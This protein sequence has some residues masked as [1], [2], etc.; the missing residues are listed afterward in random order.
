MDVVHISHVLEHVRSP[1]RTLS[2]VRRLLRSG[3]HLI[4]ETPNAAT[5]WAPLLREYSW[6]LDLPRHL[7]HFTVDTLRRLATDSGFVVRRVRIRSTPRYL[8]QSLVVALLHSE[9]V[10]AL[11][12]EVDMGAL[13]SDRLLDS[14][15]PFSRELEGLNQGNNILLVAEVP[16]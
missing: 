13:L 15:K 14:L 3:G 6:S 5:I 16:G 8:L 1:R 4:V 10:G 7:Y 12:I 2:A 11:G 9:G